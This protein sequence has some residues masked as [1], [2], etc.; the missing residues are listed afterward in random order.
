MQSFLRHIKAIAQS[1]QRMT[2]FSQS[3]KGVIFDPVSNDRLQKQYPRKHPPFLGLK[4]LLLTGAVLLPLEMMHS[5]G[6]L[7]ASCSVGTITR[8]SSP[9]KFYVDTGAAPSPLPTGMYV[10]YKITNTS[11]AAYSDLWVKLESFSGGI[12]GLATNED[13]IVHVGSLASGASTTVYVYLNATGA[14]TVNSVAQSHTVSLYSTRPDLAAGSV[15]GD[16]FSLVTEQTIKAVSNKITTVVSGPTPS[17]LGG[18]VTETIS[19]DTGQ[20]GA[21]GIFAITPASDPTWPA[22]AYQLVNTQ[23]VLS[24]GNTG[25]FNN[26]LYFS[27]LN[28]PTTAYT[29]T[30][31]YVAVGTTATPT[32]VSPVSY[33]S[34]GTQIKHNDTGAN[35]S[36]PPIQPAANT[37]TFSSK[38]AN[39]TA[40]PTGGTVNYT[41]TLTNASTNSSVSLD[42]IVDTLPSSPGVAAYVAGSAKFNG[43]AISDPKISGQTLTFLQFFTIPASS[44]RTL[45]YQATIPNVVGT[46]TNEAVGHVG[47]TQIDRTLSTTDNEPA[48]A[49]VSVGPLPVTVSGTVFDDTD[50]SKVQNGGEVLSTATGLNAVL[51][52]STTGNVIATTPIASGAFSFSNVPANTTYTV[53]ITTATAMVGSAPPAVILPAGWVNTG[54]NLNGTADGSVDGILSVPVTTSNVTTANFGIEQLPI[55]TDLTSASQTNPGG[56]TTVQVPTLAGTDPEDGALGSGKSFKIV[57][58]PTNAT[59]YYNGI[60]VTAGQTIANY[61]PTKL[62]IDPNDGAITVTFT[63]A[64]IDAAGKVDPSPATITMPFTAAAVT[65]SGTVFNDTNGDKLKNGTEAFTNGGGL[66]AVLV[67]SSNLV[68]ST[69]TVAANGTY[70]FNNVPANATYTLQIT[71]ATATVGSAPPAIVLPLNYVTT[72]ENLNGT[73]ENTPDSQQTIIVAAT[74]ITNVNFGIEQLPTSVGGTASSQVNPGTNLSI[75]VP[76]N[77]FNTSTDPDTGT[78]TQYRITAFPTNITSIEIDGVTYTSTAQTG[79]TAF[80]AVGV[81]VLATNLNTIKVDPVDGAVS[82]VIPFK[83]I[84]NAGKE[85]ANT[86]NAIV[87][88]TASVV[89]PPPEL[90]LLKRITKINSLTTG[91]KADGTPIDLTLVVAQPDNATTPRDESNDATNPNWVVNYPKGAIDG[92]V[93]QSGDLVEYTI[94][95]LSAGGKPVT[96]ANFCDWVPKNT[97]FVPDTY[98]LGRGI[99]LA[100]G[101]IVKTFTNV[102]D[103]DRGVFYNPGAVPLATYPDANTFKLNCMSPAG[104]DGAVVVNLVNN[105]LA[106]PENQLPNATAAGTPGNSY[107]FVRFVSKVK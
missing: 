50:G 36:F 81:T 58:L 4:A 34:S 3:K 9:D 103:G 56:T 49:N 68:V 8:I 39:P 18:L 94:Y 17:A 51:V 12:I 96:N 89:T 57:T 82:V 63:Y 64:A 48:T 66:N 27:G 41:I 76:I 5:Q 107:G 33:L 61:D 19:G 35:A 22:N 29:I 40:L 69:T 74:S 31:T 75:Q 84:D 78:V 88:F 83:A 26:Q 91:K 71:T 102:P 6:A 104:T 37:V 15:C 55:T 98:G 14:P 101:S 30:Y 59:L 46:Y 13:G 16:P 42:D 44:T 23:V 10:G 52:N 1:T 105:T 77:L 53:R 90:I 7:A 97:A 86:A 62:T 28:A 54:E 93:I 43:V 95:F 106:A 73:V 47:S 45:T 79:T 67:N 92:G 99:Q 60:A 65:L 21:A 100:I 70:T 11:G 20:I 38:T 25:T 32:N 80:P 24:G 2:E 85:S 87:P 72:G